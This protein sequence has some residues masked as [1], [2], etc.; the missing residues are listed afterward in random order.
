MGFV[1]LHFNKTSG[2]DS[3]MSAH[4]ERTIHPKNADEHRTHLNRELVEFPEGVTNRTDAIQHR[5]ETAG[6]KRKIGKNQVRAVRAIL[7]IT[8]EDLEQ[9]QESGRLN[10]WCD[11]NLYWLQK[12]FGTENLASAVLHL[13]EKAPHIH[14]TIVPIVCGERRK[15]NLPNRPRVKKHTGRKVPM[16]PVSVPM[17]L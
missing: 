12:T 6:I 11:E 16:L 2:N 15:A 17:I 10:E 5:I 9:I 7:S 13:D 1:S 14:A 3:A 4:I 8:Y